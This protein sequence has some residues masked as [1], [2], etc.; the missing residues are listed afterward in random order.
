MIARDKV[1]P[2]D[3]SHRSGVAR[4]RTEFDNAGIAAIARSTARSD[5]GEELADG[6]NG[7]GAVVVKQRKRTSARMQTSALCQGDHFFSQRP[8]RLGFRERGL[9]PSMLDETAGLVGEQGIPM[10]SSPAQ[11][12]RFAD[13]GA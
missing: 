9:D 5:F 1:D 6:F 4:A 3:K 10:L 12:N 11:L 2:L 8:D 13:D 7:A